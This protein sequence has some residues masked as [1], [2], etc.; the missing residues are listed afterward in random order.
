MLPCDA[1]VD[2]ALN[3]VYRFLVFTIHTKAHCNSTTSSVS[4]HLA[5][6]PQLKR[7]LPLRALPSAL[8]VQS[9]PSVPLVPQSYE[10]L[11]KAILRQRLLSRVLLGFIAF[12]WVQMVAWIIWCLGGIEGLVIGD[13]A[14]TPSTSMIA[15]VCRVAVSWCQEKGTSQLSLN[16]K[17]AKPSKTLQNAPAKQST[18][19]LHPQSFS[20]LMFRN[21]SAFN[22]SSRIPNMSEH[23]VTK[24]RRQSRR[25]W[26]D[27][28][29]TVPSGSLYERDWASIE[30][31]R[32]LP[33][34]GQHR[35][36]SRETYIAG[37]AHLLPLPSQAMHAPNTSA[38]PSL[39]KTT[40]PAVG[41]KT[42]RLFQDIIVIP[43]RT[44]LALLS[45]TSIRVKVQASQM[46]RVM[47]SMTCKQ[48]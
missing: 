20:F 7:S 27:Y 31:F 34:N 45:E 41:A 15:Y 6:Q 26:F 30:D 3:V 37:R 23:P 25:R 12:C 44:L 48:V 35:S 47:F 19:V 36:S 2:H 38:P 46:L 4:S 22:A 17:D 5:P 8:A 43:I 14:M 28:R 10:P 1:F 29:G 24:T 33:L 11:I 21:P 16:I 39:S 18:K 9:S 32:T 13:V 40:V 42:P